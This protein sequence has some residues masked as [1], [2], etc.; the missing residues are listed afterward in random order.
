MPGVFSAWAVSSPSSPV[1]RVTPTLMPTRSSGPLIGD[2]LR[3]QHHRRLAG[4][5]DAEGD[6]ERALRGDR[7]DR[8]HHVDPVGQQ[9][10]DPAGRGDGDELDRHAERLAHEVRDVDVEARR[11]HGGVDHAVGRR[12]GVDRDD[13]LA[14][15]DDLVGRDRPGR[16]G[17]QRGEEAGGW[18]AAPRAVFQGAVWSCL[19]SSHRAWRSYCRSSHGS[20][21]HPWCTDQAPAAAAGAACRGRPA[22]RNCRLTQ[23]ISVP[24]RR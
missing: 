21:P 9:R 12:R 13:D 20:A 15:A 22:A 1:P 18:R 3:R 24:S 11:L 17:R 16:R 23:F 7:E 8:D 4:I 19:G 14:A 10:R 2:A 6:L 5:G